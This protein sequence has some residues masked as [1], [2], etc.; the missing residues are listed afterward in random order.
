M[1]VAESFFFPFFLI[2]FFLIK[3]MLLSLLGDSQN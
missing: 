3:N 1:F 2:C